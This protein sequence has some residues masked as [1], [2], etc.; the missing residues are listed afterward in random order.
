MQVRGIEVEPEMTFQFAVLGSGSRGNSTVVCH[1]GGA[2]LLDRYRAGAP[3]SR[4]AAAAALAA[5]GRGSARSLLTHTH[6]D[7]VDSSTLQTLVKHGIAFYCHES[8]RDILDSDA[9]FQQLDRLELVRH[10]DEPALPLSLRLSRRAHPGPSRWSNLRFSVE[11]VNKRKTRAAA[12]GYLA[13]TGSWSESMADSLADVDIL[14]VEFNHDVAMQKSSGRSAAL[15]A[16]NL[17]DRGHLSNYQGAELVRSVLERSR[18]DKIGHLVLLHLSEQCNRPELAIH[19]ARTAVQASGRRRLDSRCAADARPPELADRHTSTCN[20]DGCFKNRR[21]VASRRYSPRCGR[22]GYAAARPEP[23]CHV[24]AFPARTPSKDPRIVS[25][26]LASDV[27]LRPDRPDRARRFSSWVEGLGKDRFRADRRRPLRLLDGRRSSESELMQ[28]DGLRSLA[29]FRDRGGSLRVMAGNHDR[30]ICTFYERVLGASIVAE[31]FETTVH[32]IRLHLVH[33]HLL[34]ARRKWKAAMESQAFFRAF[35]KL[36]SPLATRP[37]P[38]SGDKNKRGL[39]ED[40]RRHLAV[41]RRYTES[42][43]GSC[44][45]GCHRPRTSGR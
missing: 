23:G 20:H 31:P 27:H 19:E 45:S 24:T 36:P 6:G 11:C 22:R 28:C 7:H 26:Y 42:K 8:H 4:P 30:W 10:Y 33:G 37:R 32:D 18:R 43:R 5:T 44:R 34:G 29:D 39:D 16:R 17:G 12:V 9:G 14:S 2:G 21:L 41:F 13:D 25:F 3:S 35:G 15:I 40:E 1:E 38:T